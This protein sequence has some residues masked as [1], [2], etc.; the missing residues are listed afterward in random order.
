VHGRPTVKFYGDSLVSESAPE[1]KWQAALA[2]L[3]M[4]NRSYPGTVLCDWLNDMSR[5]SEVKPVVAVVAFSGNY[6]RPC[7]P[8]DGKTDADVLVAAYDLAAQQALAILGANGTEVVFALPPP[9][10]DIVSSDRLPAHY[11]SVAARWPSLVRTYDAGRLV[12]DA[13]REWTEKLP[14]LPF[15][16]EEQGCSEGEIPIRSQDHIHFCLGTLTQPRNVY[17]GCTVWSSGSWRYSTGLV[18][19]AKRGL[20]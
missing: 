11:R 3:D 20:R 8:P 19:A 6:A 16:G 10:I 7:I 1:L 9:R 18:E 2:G 4:I 13:D 14:C 12:A 15:E 17:S 5:L